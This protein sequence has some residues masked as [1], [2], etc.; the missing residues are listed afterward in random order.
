MLDIAQLLAEIS[1]GEDSLLELKEIQF[2]GD[3]IRFAREGGKPSSAI[4]EI[5][6]SLANTVGG[7]VVFGVAKAGRIL[8]IEERKR[9]LLEQFVVNVGLHDCAPPIESVLDWV[10]LPD[11]NGELRLCLVATLPKARFYVHSTTDGRYLKRVGSHRV[12]I[13]PEQLGRLLTQRSM[14]SPFEERPIYQEDLEVLDQGRFTAYLRQR[15]GDEGAD[16]FEVLE[17][18][19]VNLKLAVRD[20][21]AK[22]RPTV[23]GVLLFA[24]RPEHHLGGAFVEVAAFRGRHIEE[25]TADS[26]RIYGPIPEQ[27]EQLLH[28]FRTTPLA[29][30]PTRKD[31]I[32]RV[33][34]EKYSGL[35]F[36]EAVVNALVHRE[37]SLTG[38]QTRVLFFE[39][40]IEISNPGSLHNSLTAEDMFSG[41][42]PFRRNQLLAGFLR[43][44]RSPLTERSYFEGG[45]FGF[46]RM[47]EASERLSGRRPTLRIQSQ[48]V[49]LTIWAAPG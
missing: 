38:A 46:L 31:A 18:R 35:A 4:A 39:D 40:R 16:K 14:A 29:G 17:Q 11:P 44:Y 36:Q 13:P 22:L 30:M 45:G 42:V 27:I 48:A 9:D 23:L 24:D 6:V 10:R 43:D 37:Y 41:C 25:E 32:G 7:R 19:M 20:E 5:F 47:V 28:Y 15:F 49:H 12:M 34:L 33:D 8:G 2:K 3:Q 21:S 1:A 26:R